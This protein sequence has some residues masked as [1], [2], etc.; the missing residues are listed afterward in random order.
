MQIR[1]HCQKTPSVID[2][3]QNAS[4]NAAVEKY[5]ADLDLLLSKWIPKKTSESTTT[6]EDHGGAGQL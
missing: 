2:A 6:L 5:E 3:M 1:Y 4:G